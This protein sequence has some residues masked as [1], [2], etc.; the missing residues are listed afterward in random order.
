MALSGEADTAAG[1]SSTAPRF[2]VPAPVVIQ[3]NVTINAGVIG[4][5]FDLQ[6]TITRS[7]RGSMRTRGTRATVGA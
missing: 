2:V 6:R 3:P 7:V 1:A 4:N 5:R